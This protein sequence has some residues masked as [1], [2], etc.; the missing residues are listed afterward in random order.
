M[1]VTYGTRLLHEKKGEPEGQ[2]E[3]QRSGTSIQAR[4]VDNACSTMYVYRQTTTTTATITTIIIERGL[5][6]QS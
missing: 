1:W 2:S 4:L 5:Y 6:L 3:Y